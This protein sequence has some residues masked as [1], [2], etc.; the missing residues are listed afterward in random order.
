MAQAKGL[1]NHA[2]EQWVR[3]SRK[4]MELAF[5]G[6]SYTL[7]I[8][9][10]RQLPDVMNK[11]WCFRNQLPWLLTMGVGLGAIGSAATLFLAIGESRVGVAA[12]SS[13]ALYA[14]GFG[15][16]IGPLYTLVQTIE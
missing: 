6:Q 9:H 16:I 13:I 15:L 2:V 12:A 14:C 3:E 4:L 8:D 10:Y 1:T 5:S 7:L 11:I